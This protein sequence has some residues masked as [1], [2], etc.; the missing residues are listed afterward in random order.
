MGWLGSSSG[1]GWMSWKWW[2][3]MV[4]YIWLWAWCQLQWWPC[5]SHHQQLA[6]VSVYSDRRFSVATGAGQPHC[7]N[8]L[9]ASACLTSANFPLAKASHVA[10][11]SLKGRQRC[12]LRIA[13]AA[14]TLQRGQHTRMGGL[15]PFHNLLHCLF[16]FKVYH[17]HFFFLSFI[18]Q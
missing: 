10:N 7:T 12:H 2:S 9:Q 6:Q 14:V 15:C 5:I 11:S 3:R 8:T 4:S 18:G 1:L 17:I 13:G 16:C